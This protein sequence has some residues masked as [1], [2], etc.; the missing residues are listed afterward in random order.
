MTNSLIKGHLIVKKKR[1]KS[2]SQSLTLKISLYTSSLHR[3]LNKL[4]NLFEILVPFIWNI[5]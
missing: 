1:K 4:C 3:I 2:I 5:Y